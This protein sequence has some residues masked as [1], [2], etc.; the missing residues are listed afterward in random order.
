MLNAATNRSN[1]TTGINAN[2]C[3]AGIFVAYK[4]NMLPTACATNVELNA[5]A[6]TLL[7][8]QKYKIIGINQ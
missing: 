4:Y 5:A 7:K 8:P 6:K 2:H 1:A 3:S